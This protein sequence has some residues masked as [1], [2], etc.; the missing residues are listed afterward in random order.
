MLGLRDNVADGL[1]NPVTGEL[2]PGFP[3][4]AEDVVVDVGC[5]GAI[6]S[7]FCAEQGAH[8]IY[9]DSNPD[10]VAI[11][12]TRLAGAGARELTPIVSDA[13][14]LPLGDGTATRVIAS[15]VLEHV[16]DPRQFLRELVRVGAPGA[17]YL[18]AVPDPAAE[19]L[20]LGLAAPVYFQKPNHVRI[21][22]RSEFARMVTDAGLI[23]ER[24][25][26]YGFYWAIWWVLF[27]ICNVDI[28]E[29]HP[30]LNSWSKTW[31]ALLELPNSG[32][33]RRGLNKLLPKSQYI[34]A[35]KAKPVGVFG[36]I[37]GFLTAKIAAPAPAAAPA[38]QSNA[39]RAAVGAQS[40]PAEALDQN[41]VG[42]FDAVMGAWFKFDQKEIFPGFQI[43]GDDAILDAGCGRG[44]FSVICGR[45]GTNLTAIDSDPENIAITE[46][47]VKETG[48][49]S[50]TAVVGGTKPLP[51][52]D[53][54]FTKIIAMESIGRDSDP[55]GFLQELVRV[56][57]PGARYL[58]SIQDAVQYGLQREWAPPEYF[59]DTGA[60]KRKFGRVP[61]AQIHSFGR[62]EFER[63]VSS[64][65]LVVERVDFYGFF[66]A[67]WFAFFWACEVDFDNPHHPLLT[68]WAH[69]WKLVLEAPDGPKIKQ[70]MDS[71]L[72]RNQLILARK[73]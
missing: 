55:A 28:S 52:P 49:P 9:V 46:K 20:Q 67:L 11:A 16:D 32:P 29:S 63:M 21:I 48:I 70:R 73:P 36:K 50:F 31:D 12:G 41:S 26:S 51:F 18:L 54:S 53:V 22:G 47:R 58:L 13:N 25:G 14:P 24:R 27:W 69:T 17:L 19:E 42:L 39:H 37:R 5:G 4:T 6:D 35:R 61:T 3:V 15:E 68:Q 10:A 66:W 8:V 7:I 57:R 64:C 40:E 60:D 65:G 43:S 72:P 45:L 23:I 33:V 30:I 1:F 38:N 2:R 34:V 56:G 44:D 71:F 59:A 62:D